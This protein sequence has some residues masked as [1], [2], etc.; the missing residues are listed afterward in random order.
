[1]AAFLFLIGA[2]ATVAGLVTI[3]FGIRIYESMPLGEAL[4]VSGTC[5]AVGGFLILGVGAA[6]RELRRVG[7]LLERVGSVRPA[8]PPDADAAVRGPA[9][10]AI[11]TR[12]QPA[13]APRRP[14]ETRPPPIPLPER[15][16][17]EPERLRPSGFQGPRSPVEPPVVDEG[18]F[19]PLSPAATG[20]TVR[21]PPGLA[22][23]DG[24]FE[25]RLETPAPG[26]ASHP[27]PRF[28]APR[29][30]E[31][32]RPKRNLFDP[33]WSSAASRR[34]VPERA[35]PEP[36]PA[37]QPQS[38]EPVASEP[39]QPKPAPADR[40][41]PQPTPVSILKSGVID[42]MAYTLYT[43][44]SIE[45]QLPSGIMR[46]ESIDELRLHLEKNG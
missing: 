42:G 16:P 35:P 6:V 38:D 19:V 29:P 36:E 46:F 11:P 28:E 13:G 3:G 30:Q 1:M 22:Q 7:Q 4:I 40:D 17:P 14:A 41:Q 26:G 32:E 15:A 37:P 23:D 20:R 43:D 44:G 9:R 8:R 27:V 39:E 18:E 31:P 5:G 2:V 21:P 45:A 25:P 34:E 24:T 10:G 12:P 33:T